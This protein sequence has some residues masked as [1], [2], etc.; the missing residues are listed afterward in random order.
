MKVVRTEGL[1]VYGVAWFRLI[2]LFNVS[3]ITRIDPLR[4]LITK[5]ERANPFVA[6]WDNPR[7]GCSCKP[8]YRYID[9]HNGKSTVD[10]R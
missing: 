10:Q 5:M 3:R 6:F 7:Q 9:L 2:V 8:A 1:A 4:P